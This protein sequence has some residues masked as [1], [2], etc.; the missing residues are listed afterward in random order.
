MTKLFSVIVVFMSMFFSCSLYAGDAQIFAQANRLYTQKHFAQAL[1]L[2][3]TIAQKDAAT[4]YNMGNSAFMSADYAQARVYWRRV[5]RNATAWSLLNDVAHNLKN[6][7]RIQGIEKQ[8][9]SLAFLRRVVSTM[10]VRTLQF[11]FLFLW[12]ML[13]LAFVRVRCVRNLRI[14]LCVCIVA[15]AMMVTIRYTTTSRHVAVVMEKEA[16]L[17][18]G[19]D[20]NY[21][22]LAQLAQAREITLEDIDEHWCKV[23]YEQGVGWVKRE[24][25]TIV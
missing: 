14:P 16:T 21:H 19:P 22:V 15:V 8:E 23:A 1:A 17:F 6:L 13:V 4:W 9:S 24:A 18:A 3:K 5:E 11:L 2:Y 12:I 25:I 7:D 10:P 20:E